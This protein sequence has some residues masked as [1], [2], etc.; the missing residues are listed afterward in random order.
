M[1]NTLIADV[2]FFRGNNKEILV[3]SFSFCKLYDED[4]VQH[5]IFKPPFDFYELNLSH[6]RE[7]AHVTLNF[8][9]LDW[10]DGFVEYKHVIPIIRSCLA[11]ADE[12]F[13]KG[14]EKVK[15]LNSILPRKVCYNIE[16]LDC[17]NFKAMKANKCL[18]NSCSP[19][20]SLNVAVMKEWLL[21]LFQ[22]SLTL[23]NDSIRMF[24]EHGFFSLCEKD[25]SDVHF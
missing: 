2:Q 9:H 23:C 15:Y 22:N 17:P 20:S 19:V 3:K 16:N 13:V 6:R 25:R 7:A 8:H 4:I 14:Y 21:E 11:N 10:N 1:E 5:F 24:R 12:I 18:K